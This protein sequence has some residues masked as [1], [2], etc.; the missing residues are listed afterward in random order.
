MINRSDLEKFL[1]DYRFNNRQ[2][3][4]WGKDRYLLTIDR[5]RSRFICLYCINGKKKGFYFDIELSAAD[6]QLKDRVSKCKTLKASVID[7]IINNL[8]KQHNIEH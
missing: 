1:K 3:E 7:D 8:L 6:L 4:K 2:F 5:E